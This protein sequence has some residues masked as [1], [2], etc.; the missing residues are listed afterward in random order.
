MSI[1]KKNVVNKKNKHITMRHTQHTKH[2]KNTINNQYMKNTV[3]ININ[4]YI[5]VYKLIQKF[6]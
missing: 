5:K 2:S 6:K 1:T 4:K 3:K